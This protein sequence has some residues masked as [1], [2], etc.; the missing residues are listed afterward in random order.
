[1]VSTTSPDPHRHT[2]RAPIRTN[3]TLWGKCIVGK[4]CASEL[5][6]VGK[7]HPHAH[8]RSRLSSRYRECRTPLLGLCLTYV[9]VN[10][11]HVSPYLMQLHWLPVRSRVQFKLCTL[12]HAIHNQ[13][14]PSY[15]SDTVQT[16]A[17]A[18]TRWGLRSTVTT[19]YVVPSL[20]YKPSSHR[21]RLM[22]EPC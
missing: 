4:I 11:D 20:Y 8:C 2:P 10:R 7:I 5:V 22:I 9:I 19:D 1:M 6:V 17:T 21:T 3:D 18:T 12:M 14:S 13:R 15:L 16:V